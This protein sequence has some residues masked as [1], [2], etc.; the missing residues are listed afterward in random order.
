MAPVTSFYGRFRSGHLETCMQPPIRIHMPGEQGVVLVNG[1][2]HTLDPA[3]PTVSALAAG[4]TI[5]YAGSDAKEAV[6]ILPRA[7]VVDLHG[8]A[9]IPGLID[10]HMHFLHEGQM[11]S[12]M[13]I[14]WK[15]KEEVL[16]L[17]AEEAAHRAPGE[18][19]IGRGWNHEA[20][21]DKVW[22]DK[23]DLDAVAPANPVALSR[24]DHHS[25]WVNSAAL[26]LAGIGADSADPQGGE[27]LR[28]PDGSP[29]GILVDTG[30]FAVWQAL[31]PLSDEE[32]LR[33]CLLAQEEMLGMGIT[34]IGNANQNVR[35][36]EIFA[37]AVENGHLKIR[38]YDMLTT[39]SDEDIA[40]LAM[41]RGPELGTFGGRLSANAIKIVADGSL[42][43]RSAWL[44]R[45]YADRPGHPGNARYGDE[46]LLELVMRGRAH[47][48]QPCVHA[49]GDAAVR[50]AVRVYEKVLSAHPLP[51]H[52]F[53]I[54]HFQIARPEDIRK[55]ASLGIIPAMQAVHLASDWEM[56]EHRLDPA[57]LDD[58][59]PW[60][61]ILDAGSV[62][63]GGSD[64]PMDIVN[65]FCGIYASVSRR[66]LHGAPVGG[67]RPRQAMTREEAFKS[68]TVWAAHA[69]FG[70]GCKGM[71]KPGMF[72]D[73]AVLD[74]DIMV[75]PEDDIKDTKALLTVVGG[76]VVHD[77]L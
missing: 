77:V 59:Y 66:D 57:A 21:D 29:S 61:D 65:P 63:A 52:R 76:E 6:R 10:S 27:I 60:R 39:H 28:R 32:T 25:M 35:T 41:G 54:E 17:V 5:L 67:W 9:V 72:A 30:M 56:A 55:A 42:G 11:L 43:S 13:N 20:W 50:Q 24:A 53:R 8:R 64:A 33:L 46:E 48:F 2:I 73:F 71:L 38:I 45:D 37:R 22:P 68:Y 7:R 34:S 15:S 19:I 12:E 70:E 1:V 75:C 49:I 47:G 26:E 44:L 18:W 69:E 14:Y 36:H 4:H 16:R 40:W 51:D 3:A 74:R 62:I 58:A 31:P 23:A